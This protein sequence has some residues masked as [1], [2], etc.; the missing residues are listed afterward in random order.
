MEFGAP[1]LRVPAP[2]PVLPHQIPKALRDGEA[3]VPWAYDPHGR[4]APLHPHTGRRINACDPR[5]GWPMETALGAAER[6]AEGIGRVLSAQDR[7]V[8]IDIDDCRAESGRVSPT[9]RRVLDSLP[10]AFVE[11]SPSGAGLHL[12]LQSS[13]KPPQGITY[14]D[15]V[16]VHVGAGYV[17]LTGIRHPRSSRAL[18]DLTAAFRQFYE[19]LTG[20]RTVDVA[21][22]R[23]GRRAIAPLT[24]AD[25]RLVEV[26]NSTRP[27]FRALFVD[28]DLTRFGGD[29]S[30]ADAS[31]TQTLAWQTDDPDQI[32]RIWLASAHTRLRP[33]PGKLARADYAGNL[34][35]SALAKVAERRGQWSAR[36]VLPEGWRF[37]GPILVP[38]QPAASETGRGAGPD[39]SPPVDYGTAKT[40][41]VREERRGGHNDRREL[42]M[43]AFAA[44]FKAH[45]AEH[46]R[47]SEDGIALDVTALAAEVGVSRRTLLRWRKHAEDRG[48]LQSTV[49]RTGKHRD[50]GT[51]ANRPSTSVLVKPI[52]GAE[53]FAAAAAASLA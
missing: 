33:D 6:H 3:F 46:G 7:V 5:V 53:V 49:I 9:A 20:K 34:I 10:G 38:S 19:S 2:L 37:S 1:L 4:K 17:T 45:E 47:I 21:P 40:A 28:G 25:R 11:F 42:V 48:W 12:W 22:V 44:L 14:A 24:E 31:V 32:A 30:R 39:P 52:G 18:P 13:W 26:L 35:G 16:E 29:D 50:A 8:V 43:A 41:H 36:R 15:G 51:G 27:V 23:L